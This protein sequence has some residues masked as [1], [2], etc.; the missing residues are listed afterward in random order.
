MVYCAETFSRQRYHLPPMSSYGHSVPVAAG[1]LQAEGKEAHGRVL[2]AVFNDARD[3]VTIDLKSAYP[4]AGLTKLE[5]QWTHERKG[6]GSLVMEDRFA[7][8]SPASFATALVAFGDWHLLGKNPES[9]RFLIDGGGGALLQV[10]VEC[11][12]PASWQVTA[13]PNPGKPTASRLGVALQDPAAAGIIRMTIRP[14]DKAAAGKAT[15]L[16]VNSIPDKLA[17]PRKA[18]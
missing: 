2:A 8:A 17:D 1:L 9:P 7:F 16:P 5:R 14:A 4:D 15:K 10:D 6:D 13:L 3:S 11:S 18:P 12:A